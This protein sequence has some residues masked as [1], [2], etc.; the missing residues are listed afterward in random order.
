MCQIEST[1]DSGL[2]VKQD[3]TRQR[4]PSLARTW[5]KCRI[6][7]A[8]ASHSQGKAS[9]GNSQ[10]LKPRSIMADSTSTQVCRAPGSFRTPRSKVKSLGIPWADLLNEGL[11]RVEEIN[12]VII[13]Y[14]RQLHKCGRPYQHYAETINAI[15]GQRLSLKRSLQGAWSLAFSWLQSEPSAHHVAM[16]VQVLMALL[17]VCILWG[18]NHVGAMLALGWGAFLRAGEVLSARRQQLV[19]PPDVGFS[20]AFALFSIMEP[21]TRFSAA[22]HQCAKLDIPDLLQY[23]EL[24]LSPLRPDQ[25]IWPFSGQTMRTRLRQLL[26]AVGLQTERSIKGKPLD[27]GSLRAGGAT[28][29]LMA[30]EDSE[31]IRRRGRW[32][33]S[34]TMEIYIQE[35]SAVQYMGTLDPDVRANVILLAGI[36]PVLLEKISKL[37]SF[38]IPMNAWRFL[39]TTP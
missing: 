7:A 13:A 2:S 16:P 17:S 39:L 15:A 9:Q 18:W 5:L 26:K 22:K 14:G 25:R 21:K 11:A 3:V 4:N 34:K 30:L 20:T 24:C 28:W 37:S 6:I 31:L 10:I 19:L 8:Q 36:F 29:A 12:A 1:N 35:V 33:N 32:V 38:N 23:V 27:L